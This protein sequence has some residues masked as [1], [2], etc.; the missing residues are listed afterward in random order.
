MD[1][2]KALENL[3]NDEELTQSE[4]MYIL[5]DNLI[6]S[7]EHDRE[8]TQRCNLLSALWQAYRDDVVMKKSVYIDLVEVVLKSDRE[9]IARFIKDNII[10]KGE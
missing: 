6:E 2:L 3:L 7:L 10:E 8:M 5:V 1:N 9:T 4:K